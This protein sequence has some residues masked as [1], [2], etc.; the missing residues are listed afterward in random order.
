M[1]KFLIVLME[2]NPYEANLQQA[3]Y[4][5]KL[6]EIEA[7]MNA[8]VAEE[9]TESPTDNAKIQQ[10]HDYYSNAFHFASLLSVCLCGVFEL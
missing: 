3:T 10:L 6:K 5:A 2:N 8:P 7:I 9:A 4:E 1:P